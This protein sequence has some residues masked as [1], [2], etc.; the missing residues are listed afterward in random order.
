MVID[1][2]EDDE[3]DEKSVMYESNTVWT[4]MNVVRS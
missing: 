3:L 2:Q 1:K 4:V